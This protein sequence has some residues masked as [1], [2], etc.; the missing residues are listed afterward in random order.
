[1]LSVSGAGV[2]LDNATG[3]AVNP[4]DPSAKWSIADPGQTLLAVAQ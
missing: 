2:L 4:A 1:L 3:P